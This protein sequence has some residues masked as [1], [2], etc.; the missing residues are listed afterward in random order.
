MSTAL[1]GVAPA[2]QGL[3]DAFLRWQCRVRQMAMRDNAGRPGEGM[4]PELTLA[5]DREPMGGIVTVLYAAP[6][7]WAI[8][9]QLGAVALFVLT[10][11]ARFAALYPRPQR[12][13]RG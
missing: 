1:P 3:R 4:I 12:I 8:L 9:H 10:I 6:L 11:R 5:G 13:A 7:Q 2:A